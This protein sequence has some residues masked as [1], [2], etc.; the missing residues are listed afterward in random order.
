MAKKRTRRQLV[1][2]H[3]ARLKKIEKAYDTK[4]KRAISVRARQEKK[5]DRGL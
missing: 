1:R 4:V 2:A 5:S 3:H